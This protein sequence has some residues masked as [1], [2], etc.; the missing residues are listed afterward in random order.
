MNNIISQLRVGVKVKTHS[1][2]LRHYPNAFS[3]P[4]HTST[5]LLLRR[6]ANG[7]EHMGVGGP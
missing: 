3:G 4:L 7:L 5:A 2:F 6:G 1:H